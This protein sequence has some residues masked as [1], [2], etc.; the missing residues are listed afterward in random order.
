MFNKSVVLR[1]LDSFFRRDVQGISSLLTE[2]FEY[3]SSLVSFKGKF[4]FLLA[5]SGAKDDGYRYDLISY[6]DGGRFVTVEYLSP[7]ARW[8][9]IHQ[10]WFWIRNAQICRSRQ[11]KSSSEYIG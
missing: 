1:Y 8:R 7:R 5:L 4:D 11:I 2:D 10:Q 6:L 3:E 9:D